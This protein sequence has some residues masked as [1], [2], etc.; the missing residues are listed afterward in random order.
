MADLY[1]K[2]TKVGGDQGK[3]ARGQNFALNGTQGEKGVP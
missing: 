1:S 3:I 2:V